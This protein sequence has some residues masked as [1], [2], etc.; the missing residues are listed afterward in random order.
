MHPEGC[1]TGQLVQGVP[2][3]SSAPPTAQ[4]IRNIRITLHTFHTPTPSLVLSKFPPNEAFQTENTAQFFDF[5]HL[6]RTAISS[7]PNLLL[8][9]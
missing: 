8:L 9:L 1:A 7:L 2:Y 6:L 5:V 3:V 4:L